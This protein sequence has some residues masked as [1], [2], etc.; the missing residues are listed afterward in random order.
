MLDKKSIDE[1]LANER[2]S[3]MRR[4]AIKVAKDSL[5]ISR[6]GRSK[7]FFSVADAF[8]KKPRKKKTAA[9]VNAW[10]ALHAQELIW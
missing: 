10:L 8:P 9:E 3:G 2:D 4:D 5:R 6:D 1:A 7:P